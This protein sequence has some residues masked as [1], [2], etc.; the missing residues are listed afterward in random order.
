M[1]QL[2]SV[3]SCL[4][5]LPEFKVQISTELFVLSQRTVIERTVTFH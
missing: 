2:L 1:I 5:F 3:K 4:S